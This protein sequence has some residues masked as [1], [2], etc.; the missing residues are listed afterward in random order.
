MYLFS[1]LLFLAACSENSSKEKIPP[2]IEEEKRTP[3]AIVKDTTPRVTGI[4]G[5]FFKSKDTKKTKDWYGKNLGLA[6]DNY[7]SAFEFRNANTPEE[8]NYLRWGPFNEKTDYFSPSEK[9]FMINYRVHNLEGL[10]KRLRSNGVT[11]TDTVETYS[12]GKFVHI[13]DND[14]NKIELWEPVDSIFTNMGG[15]TTK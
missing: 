1:F 3:I 11:I 6:I 9:E 8:I 14:G 2:T 12:Y 5:I 15:V 4:G 10:L 13:M 7:G